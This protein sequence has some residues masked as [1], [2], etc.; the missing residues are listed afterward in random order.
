MNILVTG[1]SG[2]LG[3]NLV[4]KAVTENFECF[5]GVRNGSNIGQ[6]SDLESLRFV[7]LPY[8]SKDRLVQ[9][10]LDYKAQYGKFD[11]IIHNAGLTKCKK[12]SDF[13]EVNFQFTKTFVEALIEADC[14]PKKFIYI[15]SLSA[16]GPGRI[17][18][19]Q[20]IKHTD[21]PCPN[22]LYGKSKRK[23]E[24]FLESTSNTFPYIIVRSTGIYGPGDKEYNIYIST[25]DKGI[26]VQMG[27]EDQYLSFIYIEDLV[28]VIFSL[29][30]SS[31][32]RKAY[33]VSDGRT[34]TQKQ[35]IHIV[36][37]HFSGSTVK[38]ILPMSLFKIL[39]YTFD[40]IGGLFGRVPVLNSD[41]YKIMS[42]RNWVCD[43]SELEKD[44]DFTPRY[45]LE[46]GIRDTI[47][48]YL[49]QKLQKQHK[50][51]QKRII[52]NLQMLC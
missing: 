11:Y 46:D 14:V 42:A 19:F 9:L 23:A 30:E 29:L 36:R 34:Y 43:I 21:A 31:I 25:I 39:C 20:P 24:E 45:Y 2:F 12:K 7:N 35:Y 26:E 51:R 16:V 15:S 27:F 13:D 4:H 52:H 32:E 44:I 8:K 40:F 33:F 22:T 48:W 28:N 3:S 1:A 18:P 5:A 49:E 47:V 10:L 6:F 41:K 37:N 17:N 38:V 50:R